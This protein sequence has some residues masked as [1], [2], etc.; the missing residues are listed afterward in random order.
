MEVQVKII[1]VYPEKSGTSSSGNAWRSLTF[2]G[3][4]LD[5]YPKKICFSMFTDKITQYAHLL[6]IGSVLNVSFDIS[7]NSFK[8]RD[9]VER[10]GNNVNVWQIKA[11]D[12]AAPVPEASASGFT[13]SGASATSSAPSRNAYQDPQPPRAA[14][15]VP[16]AQND[17]LPF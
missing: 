5:Q 14:Q 8:G 4:T 15:P 13:T 7:A 2:I 1:T 9:G 16:Q 10:W 11:A 3:E 6:T 12:T 17:D